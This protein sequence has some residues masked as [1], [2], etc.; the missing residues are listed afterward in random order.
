MSRGQLLIFG[1]K[2]FHK[3]IAEVLGHYLY[4]AACGVLCRECITSLVLLLLAD[5]A[6]SVLLGLVSPRRQHLENGLVHRLF[7]AIKD[8]MYLVPLLFS[9]DTVHILD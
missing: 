8:D 1:V 7:T 3:G 2:G 5:L 4:P 6:V 9:S